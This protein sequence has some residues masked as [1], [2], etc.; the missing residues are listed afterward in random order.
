MT[1]EKVQSMLKAQPFRPF[2]M[3]LVDGREFTIDH[4][5]F[6][7]MVP[8]DR[9][10]VFFERGISDS[11]FTIIDLFLVSTLQPVWNP[12]L[13]PKRNGKRKKK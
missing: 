12:P 1:A 7:W 8:N 10:V 9:T 2:T 13:P 4:P 3:T 6:L 11:Y 5:E